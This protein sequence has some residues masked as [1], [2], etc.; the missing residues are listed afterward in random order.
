MQNGLSF[1]PEDVAQMD[2][3]T[4]LIIYETLVE[5]QYEQKK[6]LDNG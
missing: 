4:L 1:K 5:Q 3:D 2:V 6:A